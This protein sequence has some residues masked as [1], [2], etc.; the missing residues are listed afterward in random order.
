M[1]NVSLTVNVTIMLIEHCRR[2]PFITFGEATLRFSLVFLG[3]LVFSWH[4][5]N[6]ERGESGYAKRIFKYH[7]SQTLFDQ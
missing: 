7:G 1:E 5:T 6:M 3:F 2:L 4:V